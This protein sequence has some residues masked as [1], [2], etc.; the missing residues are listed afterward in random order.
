MAS[1]TRPLPAAVI[2]SSQKDEE[3]VGQKIR[4][5][6]DELFQHVFGIRRWIENRER[7]QVISHLLYF[8]CTTLSGLQTL[9]EEHTLLLLVHDH[10]LRIPSFLVRTTC[11]RSAETC[12]ITRLD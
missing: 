6:L 3:F 10:R 1:F 7:L 8:S 9:G 12:L 4:K 11:P 5:E 2:R